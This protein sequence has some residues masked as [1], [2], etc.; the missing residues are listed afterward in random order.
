MPGPG[1]AVL[2]AAALALAAWRGRALSAGGAAAAVLVG[3]AV[4]AGT[5]WRGGAVLAAF[6]LSSTLLGRGGPDPAARDLDARGDR[7][8]AVQ[9]LANGGP[10]AV[11]AL[12]ALRHPQ[13]GFW[14]LAAALAVATADTWASAW[15]PRF[16]GWPRDL[17]RGRRVP[18]GTSGAVS[19]AGTA[20]GLAGAVFLAAVAASLAGGRLFF[21]AGTVLG[22]GGML[23]DSA[24]GSL[25]QARFYCPRCQQPCE[26]ARHR[27]GAAAQPTGGWRWL[28]NDGVNLVAT[29][30]GALG[31]WLAWRWLAASS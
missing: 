7:R 6:F 10:A 16:G 15:G 1:L 23:G 19:W 17:F 31:G 8:D 21:P 22:F 20:A 11:G 29:G 30:A 24:L 27:C 28:S 2:V 3:T 18:P 13:A 25:V 4:L 5:G 26:R 14:M 9:V 12:V